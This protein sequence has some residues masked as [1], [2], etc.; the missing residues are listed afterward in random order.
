MLPEDL[1]LEERT[2]LSQATCAQAIYRL[3]MGPEHFVRAQRERVTG[4][5]FSAEGKL[6]ILGPQASRLLASA[7]LFR[8]TAGVGRRGDRGRRWQAG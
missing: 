5:A 8:L 2:A 4:R 1:E 7:G 6:P 3:E